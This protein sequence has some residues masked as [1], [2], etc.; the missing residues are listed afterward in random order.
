MLQ[1]K[2]RNLQIQRKG[3]LNQ[4]TIGDYHNLY[5]GAISGPIRSGNS[6]QVCPIYFTS[7]MKDCYFANLLRNFLLTIPI[8]STD[9]Y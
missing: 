8:C 5:A 4:V 1:I 9:F 3:W 2:G 6:T 7:M